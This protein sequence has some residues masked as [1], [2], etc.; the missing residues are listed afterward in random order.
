MRYTC[1]R[2]RKLAARL[3]VD[4]LQAKIQKNSKWVDGAEGFL[5]V[6]PKYE[7]MTATRR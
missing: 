7:K 5:N 4:C 6:S 2:R 3:Y 1:N